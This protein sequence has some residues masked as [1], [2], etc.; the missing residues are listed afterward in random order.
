M[1][2]MLVKFHLMVSFLS[3]KITLNDFL[4]AISSNGIKPHQ[5]DRFLLVRK[6]FI[7]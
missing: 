1:N 7:K 3:Q 6:L 5:Y 4:S 2:Y